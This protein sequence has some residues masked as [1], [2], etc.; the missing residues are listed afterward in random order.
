M[1]GRV[2]SLALN[3]AATV[4]TAKQIAAN[5]ANA[6]RSTG[7]KTAAG[8]RRSSRNAYRHGLSGA[9]PDDLLTIAATE[10]LAQAVLCDTGS[11]HED[12]ITF[13]RAQL[14]L[15]LIRKVRHELLEALEPRILHLQALRRLAALD[16][17]ERLARTKSR[18]AKRLLAKLAI[19]LSSD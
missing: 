12:A 19:N 5:R 16:R 14:K 4:A 17:Y 10:A 3:V 13:A 8:K 15:R 18:R 9:L 2:R 1:F 11:E 7:P 6:K